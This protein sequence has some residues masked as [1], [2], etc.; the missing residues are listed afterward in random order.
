MFKPKFQREYWLKVKSEEL[1]ITPEELGQMWDD[2]RDKGIDRGKQFHSYIEQRLLGRPVEYRNDLA[3]RY[4]DQN[5]D[6]TVFC[7]LKMGC[8][9]YGGTLDNLVL[10]GDR[11]GIKDWKTNWKF[12]KESR[13]TFLEPLSHL[14]VTEFYTYAIQQSLYARLLG[15]QVSFLEIVWIRDNDWVTIEMP[16]LVN[17]VELIISSLRA[18]ESRI[19]RISSS[20]YGKSTG[21]HR[22]TLL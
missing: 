16:N 1:G 10:R 21:R 3:E 13:F 2:K 15:E 19:H 17:E 22:G 6:R 9:L 12:E 8:S 11:L 20:G 5:T 7:E 4:L 18:Y 14:P